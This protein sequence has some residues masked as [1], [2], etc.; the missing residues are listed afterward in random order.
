MKNAA[1]SLI[2]L[3]IFCT[4]RPVGDINTTGS[5]KQAD[6]V[7]YDNISINKDVIYAKDDTTQQVMDIYLQGNRTGEPNW[8][9]ID[10]Q[11]HPVLIYI[12]GGGWLGGE[13]P[14]GSH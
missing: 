13:V 12:H 4:C 10:E 3:S 1:L 2:F 14:P 9:S 7:Y 5:V 8:F 6:Q 11:T